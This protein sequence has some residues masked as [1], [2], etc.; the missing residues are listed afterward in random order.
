[1]VLDFIVLKDESEQQDLPNG[2]VQEPHTDDEEVT[3][4]SKRKK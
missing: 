2:D 3:R 1:M 4:K